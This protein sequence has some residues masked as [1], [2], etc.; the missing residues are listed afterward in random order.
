M[1][2]L[3][4]D[5]GVIGPNPSPLGGTWAWVVTEGGVLTRSEAG[6]L[7]PGQTGTE[8]V[9]NNNTELWAILEG[10]DALRGHEGDW[11]VNSDSK[12]ALGWVFLA[13]SRENVPPPLRARLEELRRSG[14]LTG[15]SWRLLQGHPTKE[16]LERG[17]GKARGLPVSEW[18]KHADMLC[19]ETARR[20][21]EF[22]ESLPPA[23]T[24]EPLHDPAGQVAVPARCL[25][26]E[27]GEPVRLFL[28]IRYHE[29]EAGAVA[30]GRAE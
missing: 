5:G 7:L 23:E 8:R 9:T 19:G 18:N 24:G 15:L 11:R 1:R 10:I 28:G 13:Y 4:T 14:R 17:V 6:T 12:I 20:F 22:Q 30:C 2:E 27:A 26:C 29:T 3:W 16:D 21:R 25:R